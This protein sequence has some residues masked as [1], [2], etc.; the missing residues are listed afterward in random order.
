[1]SMGKVNWTPEARALVAPSKHHDVARAELP[2]PAVAWSSLRKWIASQKDSVMLGARTIA[3]WLGEAPP[4]LNDA[5]SAGEVWRLLGQGYDDATSGEREFAFFLARTQSLDFVIEAFVTAPPVIISFRERRFG[6]PPTPRSS[7]AWR[8]MRVV[9]LAANE[10]ER[11]RAL[12]GVRALTSAAE[13]GESLAMMIEESET[14]PLCARDVDEA[15]ARLGTLDWAAVQTVH[16]LRFDL[17]ARFGAEAAPLLIDALGAGR[18]H[19][20]GVEMQIDFVAALGHVESAE[21]AEHLQAERK[22]PGTSGFAEA[23]FNK[24]SPAEAQPVVVDEAAMASKQRWS[25]EVFKRDVMP[26]PISRQLVWAAYDEGNFILDTFRVAA[27]G[28]LKTGADDDYE[29]PEED[30]TVGIVRAEELD[31]ITLAQW[32]KVFADHLI[33]QPFPQL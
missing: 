6:K 31:K 3:P 25:V 15:R 32:S 14:S 24:S 27:D 30:A 8:A 13:F 22:M 21:V 5:P 9:W 4:T 11:V 26:L 23:Y 16:A 20:M 10:A 1:M 28:A 19:A 33:E 2:P 12:P 17:L 18:E 29:L 7:H